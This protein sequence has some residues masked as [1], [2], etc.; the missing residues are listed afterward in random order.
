MGGEFDRALGI[1][2]ERDG[3]GAVGVRLLAVRSFTEG[4]DP[5]RSSHCVIAPSGGVVKPDSIRTFPPHPPALLHRDFAQENPR[6]NVCGAIRG[7]AIGRRGCSL[8]ASE[9][10]T[11]P[12]DHQQAGEGPRK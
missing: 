10:L 2:S 1:S 7:P 5:G 3:E 9:N 11:A 8:R 4:E 6:P 12:P